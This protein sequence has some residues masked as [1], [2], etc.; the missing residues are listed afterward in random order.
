MRG[1]KD[2]ERSSQYVHKNKETQPPTK[3]AHSKASM[4]NMLL[5]RSV[6]SGHARI[7]QLSL[8]VIWDQALAGSEQQVDFIAS[9]LDQLNCPGVCNALGGFAIDLHYLISNL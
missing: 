6:C 4:I 3:H 1:K 9:S 8:T 5:C 7:P 2:Q